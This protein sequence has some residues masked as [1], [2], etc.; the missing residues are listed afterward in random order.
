MTT[1]YR[2][3]ENGGIIVAGNLS[4]HA[5]KIAAGAS[6]LD[7]RSSAH[8]LH[9]RRCAATWPMVARHRPVQH[10]QTAA[11]PKQQHTAE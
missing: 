9:A 8:A 2:G 10:Q 3:D 6:E 1:R 5:Q 7:M 4:E 11:Q